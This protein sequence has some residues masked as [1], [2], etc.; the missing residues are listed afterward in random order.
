M[1]PHACCVAPR[2]SKVLACRAYPCWRNVHAQA[3]E[4]EEEVAEAFSQIE[5]A[6]HHQPKL[7]LQHAPPPTITAANGDLANGGVDG[8]ADVRAAKGEDKCV[9][10][11]QQ[12]QQKPQEQQQ[13]QQQQQQQEGGQEQL[14]WGPDMFGNVGAGQQQQAKIAAGVPKE[15]LPPQP[16]QQQQQQQ[17]QSQQAKVAASVPKEPEPPQL[18][19]LRKRAGLKALQQV[20]DQDKA[21]F[22]TRVGHVVRATDLGA[23]QAHL[24][25]HIPARAVG[26]DSGV[27]QAR[28]RVTRRTHPTP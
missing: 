6:L 17:Q 24:G 16:P 3:I 19:Q 1:G 14:P 8:D 10:P 26:D 4:L 5:G 12:Q 11:S 25:G 20:I 18:Q 28:D 27:R 21:S 13:Q 7:L 23:R 15:P 9:V 2:R 22:I